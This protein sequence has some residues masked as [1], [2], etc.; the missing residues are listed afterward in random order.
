[1][2][3]THDTSTSHPEQESGLKAAWIKALRSGDY[4]QGYGALKYRD[5]YCCMGVLC[6]VLGKPMV[7]ST[8]PFWYSTSLAYDGSLVGELIGRNDVDRLTFPEIADWLESQ[9][10]IDI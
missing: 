5:E 4:R 6:A 2:T 1:M 7:Y 8:I 10:D 3:T 9:N